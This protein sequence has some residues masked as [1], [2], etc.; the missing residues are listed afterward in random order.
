MIDYIEIGSSPADESCIQVGD[1][2][3]YFKA[4]REC[5][6]FKEQLKRHF[7]EPPEG[8]RL[9]VKRFTH[10]F[11]IYMEVVCYFDDAYPES[12]DYAF[13]LEGETPAKWDKEA[14]E[15]LRKPL[16]CSI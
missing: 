8:A 4:S 15:E 9:A 5:R 6:V 1:P 11:G 3:Y 12:I 16:S 10:D 14:L 7:G 13:K 2:D